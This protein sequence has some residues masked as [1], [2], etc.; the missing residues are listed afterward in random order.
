[1][2]EAEWLA[3]TEPGPMLEFLRAAIRR[4]PPA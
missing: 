2:G 3:Y 4:L 1:M